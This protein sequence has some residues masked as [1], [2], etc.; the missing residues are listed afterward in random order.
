M[1][2][3]FWTILGL[4]LYCYGVECFSCIN[5]GAIELA[6]W[7]EVSTQETSLRIWGC[8]PSTHKIIK[9]TKKIWCFKGR[10]LVS[11]P[12]GRYR[13]ILAIPVISGLNEKTLHQWWRRWRVTSKTLMPTF[14]FYTRYT[15]V[16]VQPH[17]HAPTNG[18]TYAHI[19]HTH[20]FI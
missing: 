15:Y 9:W 11:V 8:I 2:I 19:A 1:H 12:R 16:Y 5:L 3:E 4:C 6:Q 7:L 20:I 10:Y 13:Y 18:T 17:T 14:P